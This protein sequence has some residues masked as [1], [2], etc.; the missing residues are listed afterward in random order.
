MHSMKP[1]QYYTDVIA[2]PM[3]GI[4]GIHGKVA[5]EKPRHEIEITA[6]DEQQFLLRQQQYLQQGA[7]PG[8]VPVGGVPGGSMGAGIPKTPDRKSM[9]SPGVQGSPTKKVI[10]KI[11]SIT[12]N[13]SILL[14]CPTNC[15][16]AL[17]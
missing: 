4:R 17:K 7:Q 8:M 12:S 9:G 3:T 16:I 5:N 2:R 1:D 14:N 6:E 11:K 10:L 13:P 15:F